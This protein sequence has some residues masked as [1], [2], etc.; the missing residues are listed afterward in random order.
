MKKLALQQAWG[1]VIS[2]FKPDHSTDFGAEEYFFYA[3]AAT[4]I[5]AACILHGAGVEWSGSAVAAAVLF[6][7]SATAMGLN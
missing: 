3:V 5:V 2:R 4:L 7:G 6:A 1:W